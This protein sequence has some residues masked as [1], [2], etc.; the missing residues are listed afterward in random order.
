MISS[1]FFADVVEE[2]HE[3]SAQTLKTREN[4]EQRTGGQIS[5]TA[6]VHTRIN[7]SD[8]SMVFQNSDKHPTTTVT[9]A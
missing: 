2:S 5:V 6:D 8:D 9:W 1:T 7:N 4:E 3:T